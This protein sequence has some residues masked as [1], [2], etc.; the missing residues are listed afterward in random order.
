MRLQQSEAAEELVHQ[1]TV[2]ATL[3]KRLRVLEVQ[4]AQ[5]G[6]N[7]APHILIEIDSLSEQIKE[8]ESEIDTLTSISVEGDH[9]LVEVEYRVLLAEAWSTSQGRPTVVSRT[10]LE[11]M[12][13]RLG[14]PLERASQLEQDV[15]GE[16]AREVI[17]NLHDAFFHDYLQ[18]Y[19]FKAT[20][21][22]W[23]IGLAIRLNVDA[24]I[25]RFTA[26]LP[27]K[28]GPTDPPFERTLLDVN[29]FW[30]YQEQYS[31]DFARFCQALPAALR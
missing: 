22:F 1:R 8:R 12:R 5:H 6:T 19:D 29:G 4:L 9:S 3:R 15:R 17:D 20:D 30:L 16:V 13:L 26:L 21:E 27:P 7:V 24:A 25:E 23:K 2:L 31:P 18:G 14:I 11:L 10:R 28:V